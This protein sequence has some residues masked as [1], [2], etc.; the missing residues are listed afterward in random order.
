MKL[1]YPSPFTKASIHAFVPACVFICTAKG[2]MAGSVGR[3]RDS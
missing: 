3:A 1:L 2:R